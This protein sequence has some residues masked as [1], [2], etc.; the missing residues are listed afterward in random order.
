MGYLFCG[1]YKEFSIYSRHVYN[2]KWDSSKHVPKVTSFRDMFSED[3]N[4]NIQ[5][6]RA[7]K[8]VKKLRVL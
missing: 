7:C 6:I 2:K 4:V 1:K 5:Y 3:F 8:Q